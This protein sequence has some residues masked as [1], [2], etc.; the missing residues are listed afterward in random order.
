MMDPPY[1][2][3]RMEARS[4]SGSSFAP[5]PRKLELD[6][7]ARVYGSRWVRVESTAGAGSFQ[8]VPL[9]WEDLFDPQEGDHVVHS[10]VHGKTIRDTATRLDG[11]FEARGQDDVLVCDD[12]KMLWKNPRIKR[13]APDIAVIPDVKDPDRYRKSFDEKQE[14]TGPVFVLEV[15]S[16]TTVDFD[17][18]EKPDIYHQAGVREN[19]ML[20]QMESPWELSGER[21]D[22]ETGNWV[23]IEPDEGGRYLAETLGVYFSVAPSGEDLILKDAATG[24]VIRKLPAEA[25]ARREAEQRAVEEAAAR[26][27]AEAKVQKLLA[28][29]E[30]LKSADD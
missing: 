19:F 29:I 17:R 3:P 22:P 9:T 13:I 5:V 1:T 16:E 20:D 6:K 21:L 25:R 12:V 15:T 8:E 10:T 7:E 2:G 28:E 11:F 18:D 24:E 27:A 30:R 23:D 14:G 4:G 26:E